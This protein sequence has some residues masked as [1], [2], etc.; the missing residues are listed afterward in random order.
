MNAAGE[1]GR[2]S[3]RA[4][5]TTPADDT[6]APAPEPTPVPDPTPAQPQRSDDDDQ[7]N[8]ARSSHNVLVS[9][10]GK[11]FTNASHQ[12]DRS[13]S[14]QTGT[15]SDGYD[16]ASVTVYS[17]GTVSF[18][19]SIWD[20]DS[21]GAPSTLLHLLTEPSTFTAN[22]LTFTAPPQCHA[23]QRNDIRRPH[24]DHRRDDGSTEAHHIERRGCR[25][26]RRLGNRRHISILYLRY[27]H[28]GTNRHQSKSRYCHSGHRRYRHRLR[29]RNA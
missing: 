25:S 7:G 8:I 15:H 26:S 6:P 2:R 19:A 3:A 18:S 23:C 13:Q 5:A 29:R 10:T 22:T 11:T 16:L 17:G 9:N 1:E 24:R 28:L 14:F 27:G 12:A 21:D 4:E 20:A